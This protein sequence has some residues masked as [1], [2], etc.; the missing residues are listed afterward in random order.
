[1]TPYD[2]W[3]DRIPEIGA[4]S[5]LALRQAMGE[6]RYFAERF[7]RMT[8][9]ER[10][11]AALRALSQSGM[12]SERAARRKA[13][14]MAAGA[15]REP[16]QYAEE[17]EEQ[18]IRFAVYDDPE[19]PQKL[20]NLPDP[21]FGL[22]YYGRLPSDTHP[23]AAII[24]TRMAS[25][26]GRD[27]ARVF[28]R[29]IAREGVQIISGMAIGID[30]IAGR[31]ALD[32]DGDTFAV[33]GC[34]VDICYPKENL[35]L[36][37]ALLERGGILSEY[38]P[39]SEPQKKMF[40]SRN[41]IISGLSDVVLVIEA[42][43]KSGTLITVDRALEYGIDVYAL[44]GRVSDRNSRGCNE[45]IR[46][47]AGIA[48]CPQD[49]LDY[50]YGEKPMRE[51]ETGEGACGEEAHGASEGEND[52]GRRCRPVQLSLDFEIFSSPEDDRTQECADEEDSG[53]RGPERGTQEAQQEKDPAHASAASDEMRR[54]REAEQ[55]AAQEA[56]RRR[57]EALSRLERSVYD[58]LDESA[59]RGIDALLPDVRAAMGR[60]VSFQEVMRSITILCMKDLAAEIR[61]GNYI[62]VK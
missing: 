17:M 1:M 38:P 18:E 36:Y 53:C 61:V 28:A 4:A 6:D 35:D 58:A 47:G 60:N 46:Q 9:A 15:E 37:E 11:A 21:P 39:G 62:S 10:E 12:R 42:R 50:I 5:I 25:A 52:P 44:P 43:E 29:E 54:R 55:A 41:R 2:I 40:P 13:C 48:T 22:Y 26:Y 8:K 59:P 27:Q 16:G 51:S 7:Y 14:L 34:G 49:I 45:L 24:G 56:L 20:R 33:L 31:G 32:A 57:L 3:L 23:S 30:G 19:Y